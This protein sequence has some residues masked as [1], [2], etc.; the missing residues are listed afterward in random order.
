LAGPRLHDK[1]A[2]ITGGGSGIG[3]ASAILF[4]REGARVMVA[5]FQEETLRETVDTIATEG[6][7]AA[8]VVGDVRSAID[9]ERIVA[10]TIERWGRIDVLFNNAGIEFVGEIHETPE[11]RWDQVLDTNLKGIYLVS[12]AAIP[13]LIRQGG[14][15]IVNT[16]S[17]LGL[18]AAP[19]F[20]AYSAS[21]GGAVN[22]T[23]AM[24]LDLAK[25]NIRV[26]ALCPGAV[27][28]PLLLRQFAGRSG[29]QGTL[30][31]L[32]NLHALKRLAQPIEIAY[33]ALFLA[34]DE[35]SFMTG[36]TLVVDGGYTAW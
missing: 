24:A 30:E 8:Y 4:A 26:N 15:A 32:A 31:D 6:N 29:P 34:S 7:A 13:H 10:A 33:P 28:T 23:R 19:S 14:G 9:A 20:A 11:E 22:L 17:Q 18:V 21:K 16:A 12:K 27:E 25:Y 5:G 2:L 1:A 3:R 36:S 35:S